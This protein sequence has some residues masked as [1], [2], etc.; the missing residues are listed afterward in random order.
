MDE[1]RFRATSDSLHQMI[2]GGVVKWFYPNNITERNH[3]GSPGVLVWG[4]IMLNEGIEFSVFDGV[5]TTDVQQLLES[6]DI[7][8]T[9][10]SASFYDSNPVA[11]VWDALRRCFVAQLHPPGNKR[12]L[13]NC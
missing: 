13:K 6:N 4:G 8:R 10:W 3:Y 9:Y 5:S 2:C 11:H 12:Q 1:S 7:T